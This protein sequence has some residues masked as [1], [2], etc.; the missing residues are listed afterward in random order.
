MQVQEKREKTVFR[1]GRRRVNG[2]THHPVYRPEKENLISH[3]CMPAKVSPLKVIKS[4][5]TP[6][7]KSEEKKKI[8]GSKWEN[9]CSYFIA[10]FRISYRTS[11]HIYLLFR[12]AQEPLGFSYVNI[13]HTSLA[14][15]CTRFS[16]VRYLCMF[17]AFI[18][19]L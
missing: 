5:N 19:K 14:P 18:S 8:K 6:T 3:H 15:V 17:L 1:R 9:Y 7:K 16:H 12:L 10:H 4:Q 2:F 11:I 13:I